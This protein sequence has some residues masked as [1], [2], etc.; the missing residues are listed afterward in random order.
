MFFMSLGRAGSCALQPATAEAGTSCVVPAR[1]RRVPGRGRVHYAKVRRLVPRQIDTRNN[2]NTKINT[3]IRSSSLAPAQLQPFSSPTPVILQLPRLPPHSLVLFSFPSIASIPNLLSHLPTTVA[4]TRGVVHR[5]PQQ[6]PESPAAR[7]YLLPETAPLH[8]SLYE[9]WTRW[10]GLHATSAGQVSTTCPSREAQLVRA[11]PPIVLLHYRARAAAAHV[12]PTSAPHGLDAAPRPRA[13][14]LYT[15]YRSDLPSGVGTHRPLRWICREL[16]R[17]ASSIEHV[18]TY[19]RARE[20]RDRAA[21][22]TVQR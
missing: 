17:I 16:H 2:T 19:V 13:L 4:F 12:L 18:R 14:V 8:E 15:P 21:Y 10:A 20:R 3:C 9:H 1:R 5:L 22:C 6:L 7:Q 11:S